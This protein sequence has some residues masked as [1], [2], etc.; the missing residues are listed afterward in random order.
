MSN[1]KILRFGLI[2]VCLVVSFSFIFKKRFVSDVVAVNDNKVELSVFVQDG[3]H[4]CIEAEKWL[5]TNPFDGKVNVVYYNLGNRDN[6]KVLLNH[7]KRL[8]ID[9]SDIGT[10]IFVIKNN[11]VIGFSDDGREQVARYVDSNYEEK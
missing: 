11:Y 8:K 3:C 5:K 10:P 1:K 7:A 6:V 2:A 9:R 4:Y